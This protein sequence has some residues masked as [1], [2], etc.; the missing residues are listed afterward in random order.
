MGSDPSQPQKEVTINDKVAFLASA[1]AYPAESAKV[2]VVETH[3]SWVFLTEHY[4]YK[5]KKP[6]RVWNIDYRTIEARHR[7][8]IREVC[9]NQRLAPAVYLSVVGLTVD[10]D[11]VFHLGG[12]G[13]TV[14][15]LVKMRRLPGDRT[16]ERRIVTGTLR[17][18]DIDA[19]A[20]RLSRFYR[21]AP[22]L[23]VSTACYWESLKTQIAETRQQLQQPIYALDREVVEQIGATLLGF[24]DRARDLFAE[25]VQSGHIV[26]GHGD[27]RP[28]HIYLCDEPIIVDCLE[29]DRKLRI[30]D[31][32]SELA[33][34]A[35]E[36]ERLGA[37]D[38]GE[39]LFFVYCNETSDDP[40]QSL[41]AFHKG[42]HAYIRARIAISHLDDRDVRQPEKWR[43]RT[44]RYL[45][46]AR[47]Y[48]RG[49]HEDSS[50][51]VPFP[52]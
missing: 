21:D 32:A 51:S 19:I 18:E 38:A 50:G 40:S 47:N 43:N 29:F 8:C 26:E 30:L 14:D 35:M 52:G 49:L 11:G 5:L 33:F 31:P 44:E 37:P 23:P 1:A 7:N 41:I 24:L 39:R 27:L 36:C 16:L 34:L 42:M 13:H 3:L 4:A 48:I 12:S 9:L 45:G 46:L 17:Q 22:R 28:E 20:H 15:W 6:I 25:R 10:E 2:E